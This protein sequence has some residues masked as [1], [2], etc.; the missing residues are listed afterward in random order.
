MNAFDSWVVTAD[1]VVLGSVVDVET[2]TLEGGP[3]E[4]T[5]MRT[6]TVAIDERLDGNEPLPAEVELPSLATQ[7]GRQ[8]PD[9]S[10]DTIEWRTEG[11]LLVMALRQ[12]PTTG[13]WGPLN[14]SQFAW[15]VESRELRAIS[16]NDDFQRE[17]SSWSLEQFRS[18][19]QEARAAGHQ[20]TVTPQPS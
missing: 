8:L 3:G 6:V 19:T 4:S 17:V 10:L 13:T 1:A 11:Q 12:E 15:V 20:G 18:E 2:W 9:G 7:Y 14:A 16:P 5:E